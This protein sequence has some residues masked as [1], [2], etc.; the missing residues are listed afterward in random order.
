MATYKEQVRD[1]WK[2]YREQVSP[3]PVD[4]KD[5][6]AWAIDKKLWKPRPVDLHASL[7]SDL[8]D[9]L[10]DETRIDAKGRKYRVNIPVRETPKGGP[11][12]FKWAD[13]DF[14]PHSHVVKNVQQDRRS[15]TSDCYA[16]AMKVEHYNDA[17][18]DREQIQVC[19]NFEEDVEEAKIARGILD[20]N[21][22]DEAA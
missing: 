12:L 17:Y 19:F 14:A 22:K 18:P 3:D 1:I 13:L 9:A 7:A 15:I 8:A 10:R 21:D 5:V 11:S 20:D 6:A 2:K 4:L 16:L